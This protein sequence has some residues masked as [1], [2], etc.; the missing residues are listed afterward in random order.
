MVKKQL[1]APPIQ[2]F[3]QIYIAMNKI[4]PSKIENIKFNLDL[5]PYKGDHFFICKLEE[6]VWNTKRWNLMLS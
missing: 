2:L 3:S 5:K 1:Y 4:S 6:Y